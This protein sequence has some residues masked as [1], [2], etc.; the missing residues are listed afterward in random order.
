MLWMA[1][2][3]TEHSWDIG[4][5]LN[6]DSDCIAWPACKPTPKIQPEIVGLY[7][8]KYSKSKVHMT[9]E[10]LPFLYFIHHL[11]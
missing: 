7:A 8:S 9:D 3:Q 5:I 1:H 11:P 10:I 6:V 4:V 2:T